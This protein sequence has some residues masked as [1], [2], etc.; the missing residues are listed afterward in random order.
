MT[1]TQLCTQK[2]IDLAKTE[3][4]K[5]FIHQTNLWGD[6]AKFTS[7]D[8]SEK[9]LHDEFPLSLVTKVLKTL[10]NTTDG[11]VLLQL[12]YNYLDSPITYK[13]Q[14]WTNLVNLSFVK[15]EKNLLYFNATSILNPKQIDTITFDFI[16]HT[17]N[18][19][20]PLENITEEVNYH[21]RLL[22]EN[23]LNNI[24]DI[25]E[26]I[27]TYTNDITI[28]NP[29]IN[30]YLTTF[31]TDLKQMLKDCPKG[32]VNYLKDFHR[33]FDYYNTRE[34]VLKKNLGNFGCYM[35]NSYKDIF[36]CKEVSVITK[37]RKLL[38]EVIHNSWDRGDFAA[39]LNKL[40]RVFQDNLSDKV[41]FNT[42][43]SLLT[44]SDDIESFREKCLDE[45]NKELHQKL[46]DELTALNFINNINIDNEHIV[47]VPQSIKDLQTEGNQ[48][49]N[50][51]GHYYN[52]SII[53]GVN[54]IY[55]IRKKDNTDE[56][57]ITCRYNMQKKNTV[58]ARGFCNRS[59]SQEELNI[60]NKVTNIINNHYEKGGM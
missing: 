48:Q 26:W 32:L 14:D 9:F 11:K 21:D 45:V 17:F 15:K 33:E 47:I 44:E 52:D 51:V 35:Y 4:Y 37:N 18:K 8:L 41:T 43:L 49:H 57:F 23:I 6:P 46:A 60:V 24:N 1:K 29:F 39:S 3:E 38:K 22:Y 5:T 20:L 36:S 28:I 25:P 34:Y 30:N 27:F 40:L 42:L 19:E 56:S 54:K 12:N 7:R 58:E 10:L 13:Y 50:C 2:I 16:T 31:D 53:Y 55:F 59:L